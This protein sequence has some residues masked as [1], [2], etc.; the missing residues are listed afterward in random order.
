MIDQV[1]KF[2]PGERTTNEAGFAFSPGP[3][4]TVTKSDSEWTFT[5]EPTYKTPPTK[6]PEDYAR[7]PIGQVKANGTIIPG[8][9]SWE[10]DSNNFNQADTFRIVL[11]AST[12]IWDMPLASWMGSDEIEIEILAG[13]NKDNLNSVILGRIDTL[14]Y[15]PVNGIMEINGRDLTGL[16]IDA[17]TE[18]KY[19]NQSAANIVRMIAARHGLNAA[20]IGDT[21]VIGRY[22]EIDKVKLTGNQSEWDML[23]NIAAETGNDIYVQG[24]T[25]VFGPRRTPDNPIIINWYKPDN[26]S[27][28]PVSNVK[29]LKVTRDKR[30]SNGVDV[31]IKS[32]HQKRSNK[33]I[34]IASN[35]G[36]RPIIYRR[37]SPHLTAEGAQ[38]RAEAMLAEIL[39]HEMKIE[40]T[41]PGDE[42]ITMQ[43]GIELRGTGT[44]F[45]QIYYPD[46]IY[47]EM[48][49]STGYLM[50]VTA[51]N[52]CETAPS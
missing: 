5:R 48:D 32:F 51:K 27:G 20:I 23:T 7:Q 25:L 16:L 43:R 46:S 44:V 52:K 10:T 21:P 13:L 18:E 9:V 33:H 3:E 30:I 42:S 29:T 8:W 47:R 28:C 6:H 31:E 41:I 38:Q 26:K 49:I 37:G 40:F 14:E 36:K 1:W 17:R 2:Y 12:L 4:Y 45:D 19:P 50:T 34:G 35:K 11:A 24:R 15:N 39:S 22:Y